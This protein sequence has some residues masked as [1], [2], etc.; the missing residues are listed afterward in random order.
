MFGRTA[1]AIMDSN[2]NCQRDQAVTGEGNLKFRIKVG[3]TPHISLELSLVFI[4]TLSGLSQAF[5]S[6]LSGTSHNFTKTFSGLSH[7]F[8][9]TFSAIIQD[10]LRT[11]L[12]LY[13][14][15]CRTISGL[16]QQGYPV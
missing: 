2:H 16:C 8:I 10:F 3:Q 12:G 5:L 7:N 13:Q 9:Q 4:W 1:I 15:F 11:F 14:D 6:N